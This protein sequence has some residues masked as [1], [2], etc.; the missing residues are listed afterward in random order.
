MQMKP[1]D[2]VPISLHSLIHWNCL[3]PFFLVSCVVGFLACFPAVL[4]SMCCSKGTL[5]AW[6]LWTVV[7][8]GSEVQRRE[9]S[10]I[11]TCNNPGNNRCAGNCVPLKLN[12][13][14]A[15]DVFWH[16]KRPTEAW[17]DNG[18]RTFLLR[19]KLLQSC[20]AETEGEKENL[21]SSNADSWHC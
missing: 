7:P 3:P 14:D 13:S 2:V 9:E 17:S 20:A 5:S 1:D 21:N 15:S 16:K 18:C 4:L 6:Q 19:L 8:H 11:Q 10:Y 12:N